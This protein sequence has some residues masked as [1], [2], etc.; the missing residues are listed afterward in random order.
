MALN[1]NDQTTNAN[2]LTNVNG[3]TDVTSSL[4]M[5]TSLHAALLTAS[6][7]QYFTAASSAT[8]NQATTM[9][10][11]FWIKFTT[12]P[13]GGSG[14]SLVS[15]G[16]Y[17]TD[18]QFV[19]YLVNSGGQY[20]LTAQVSQSADDTTRDRYYAVVTPS[21]ATW[22]H[23]AVTINVG[24]A[25]ATTFEFIVNGS[26]LGNGTAVLSDNCSSI[27][28]SSSVL[29]IGAD[30]NFQSAG[31]SSFVDGQFD[32]VR[33]YNAARSAAQVNSDY[34]VQLSLPL[35]SSLVAYWPYE[36]LASPGGGFF[37]FLV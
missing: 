16:T 36:V 6:S 22:Y 10:V 23:Y 17:S 34:N 25:S 15:K 3:A 1:L 11:S 8:L 29:Y 12:L 4:P 9:T 19:I 18:E 14:V 5:V 7:S 27:H 20:R 13:A 28:A 30:N 21:T 32:D 35:A 31:I 26:S 2:N 37:N 33:Y 24:N